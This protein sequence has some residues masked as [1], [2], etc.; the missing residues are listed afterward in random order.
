M[1]DLLSS[2]TNDEITVWDVRGESR[3]D[4]RFLS[5]AERTSRACADV[6]WKFEVFA[7]LSARASLNLRWLSGARRPP[8]WLPTTQD[9]VRSVV[10]DGAVISDV[11][12]G[13]DVGRHLTASMWHLIWT[14]QIA[15]DLDERWTRLTAIKWCEVS[16]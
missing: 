13:D 5:V 14:G 11:I 7:G 12:D 16:C 4:D 1:P 10:L 15:I 2:D 8:E 9:L 6:G 3:Q